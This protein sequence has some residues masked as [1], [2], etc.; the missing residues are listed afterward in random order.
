[1]ENGSII[2][3]FAFLDYAAL[4]VWV[5]SLCDDASCAA[6]GALVMQVT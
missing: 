5:G 4:K 1:M 2:Y 3:A 6:L